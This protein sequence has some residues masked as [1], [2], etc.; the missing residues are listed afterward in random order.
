MNK[1]KFLSIIAIMSINSNLYAA[2]QNHDGFVGNSKVKYNKFFN[3]PTTKTFLKITPIKIR[4]IFMPYFLFG[5]YKPGN[6]ENKN[7]LYTSGFYYNINTNQLPYWN[8]S[9]D[10]EVTYIHKD[11]KKYLKEVDLTLSVSKYNPIYK[12]KGTLTYHFSKDNTKDNPYGFQFKLGKYF[13]KYTSKGYKTINIY[14]KF[15]IE[16]Y[17]FFDYTNGNYKYN[18]LIAIK[19]GISIT[20]PFKKGLY[21]TNNFEYRLTK[22]NKNSKFLNS[23]NEYMQGFKYNLTLSKG[24]NIYNLN[25]Y[26]GNEVGT[27]DQNGYILYS[28]TEKNQN[29]WKIKYTR[30]I[31]KTLNISFQYGMSHYQVLQTKENSHLQTFGT[32]ISKSF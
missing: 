18:N 28:T 24:K 2:T 12:I 20:I 32:Y 26:I 22:Q 31:N 3:L 13:Y 23:T 14:N 4:Q 25:T 17:K 29:Y 6:S 21:I 30:I 15:S 5:K 10:P 27:M 11:R 1:V 8:F 16:R 9:I 19:P 7:K